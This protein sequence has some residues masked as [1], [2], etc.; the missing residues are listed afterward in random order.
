[1]NNWTISG[2]R[3]SGNGVGQIVGEI[4]PNI[5][6]NIIPEIVNQALQQVVIPDTGLAGILVAGVAP[7]TYRLWCEHR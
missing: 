3:I 1:M 2:N 6:T 5:P 7:D 4:L